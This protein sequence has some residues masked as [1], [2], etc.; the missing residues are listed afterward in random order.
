MPVKCNKEIEP[1]LWQVKVWLDHSQWDH[2]SNSPI[3]GAHLRCVCVCVCVC[4]FVGLFVCAY[5]CVCV[6]TNVVASLR[7]I[8]HG[9]PRERDRE[10]ESDGCCDPEVNW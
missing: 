9:R 7:V 1:R 3:L 10:R 6:R 8:L 5:L 2:F 4:S